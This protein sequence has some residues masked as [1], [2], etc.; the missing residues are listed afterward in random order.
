MALTRLQVCG[1]PTSDDNLLRR[2]PGSG[3]ETEIVSL[4]ETK[5]NLT[6]RSIDRLGFIKD[7]NS[8]IVLSGASL[9]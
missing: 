1:I 4:I 9:C 5:K 2:Y 8:L 7:I 6:R 3:E